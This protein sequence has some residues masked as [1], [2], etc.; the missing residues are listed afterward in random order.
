[1][2]PPMPPGLVTPP[3][4]SSVRLGD[5]VMPGLATRALDQSHENGNGGSV[6]EIIYQTLSLL[7]PVPKYD[8]LAYQVEDDSC[9]HPD[10]IGHA[11]MALRARRALRQGAYLVSVEICSEAGEESDRYD[12]ERWSRL[13]R[14]ML[15]TAEDPFSIERRRALI[16]SY[17]LYL[18]RHFRFQRIEPLDISAPESYSKELRKEARRYRRS[19][20]RKLISNIFS[21]ANI[22]TVIGATITAAVVKY[23]T[24]DKV[25]N[26]INSLFWNL[27]ERF[28]D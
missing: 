18:Q 16:R 21:L 15:W 2:G 19:V 11:E 28:F 12:D 1:S 10:E 22:A 9:A 4:G 27:I 24:D 3:P 8:E 17:D 23:I 14:V 5:K 13:G 20:N 25:G 7:P 6:E 26:K